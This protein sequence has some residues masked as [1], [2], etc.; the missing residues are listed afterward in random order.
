MVS[1]K[2]DRAGVWFCFC[3]PFL[4]LLFKGYSCFPL[5]VSGMELASL[6]VKFSLLW[7]RSA[8]PDGRKAGS[9]LLNQRPK[10]KKKKSLRKF[11]YNLEVYFVNKPSLIIASKLFCLASKYFHTSPKSHFWHIGKEWTFKCNHHPIH[12]SGWSFYK[13]QKPTANSLNKH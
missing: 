11:S 1:E 4:Y 5:I 3:S 9:G 13:G 2:G 12:H 7:S 6:S 10:K 8:S